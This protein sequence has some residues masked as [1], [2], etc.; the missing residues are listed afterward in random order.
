[1][2][3]MARRVTDLQVGME[4]GGVRVSIIL[5]ADDIVVISETWRGLQEALGR[6]V[7]EGAKFDMVM[8]VKKSKIMSCFGTRV[9]VEGEG[10]GEGEWQWMG[11]EVRLEEVLFYIYLGVMIEL[12]HR[13]L[14]NACFGEQ[15]LQRA[16]RYLEVQRVKADSVM[17][18]HGFGRE[19]WERVAIPGFLYGVEATPLKRETMEALERLN[20][21]MAKVALQVSP[22]TQNVAAYVMGGFKPIWYHVYRR[23]L[24]FITKLEAGNAAP[25]TL[26]VWRGLDW[27]NT[28][29]PFVRRAREMVT[30][31]GLE[32]WDPEEWGYKLE[33]AVEKWVGRELEQVQVSMFLFPPGQETRWLKRI[34]GDLGRV[35]HEF[36]VCH[37]G[38]G[39]RGPLRNGAEFKAGVYRISRI[40]GDKGVQDG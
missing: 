26:A 34:G 29:N 23:T 30:D 25:A 11:G 21:K 10:E 27:A 2:E 15:V 40:G 31:L 12:N 14:F 13:H 3:P 39:N 4:V 32:T 38:L 35:Y 9:W 19:L 5:F 16:R 7:E 17:D 20:C 6:V 33:G 22:T 28:G 36:L 8:N 24:A 37:A 1:M 18:V